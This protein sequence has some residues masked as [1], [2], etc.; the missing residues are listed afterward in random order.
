MGIIK[1]RS[2]AKFL[3]ISTTNFD[4]VILSI[5]LFGNLWKAEKIQR[6]FVLTFQVTQWL[7]MA[8]AGKVMNKFEPC[9]YSWVPLLCSPV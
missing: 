6:I 7:F 9:I 2:A 3:R 1:T 4:D 5:K 8:L